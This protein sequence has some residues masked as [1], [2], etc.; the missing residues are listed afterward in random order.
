MIRVFFLKLLSLFQPK[1]KK[2]KRIEKEE[3]D[4]THI[5]SKPIINFP[6]RTGLN[7]LE[8]LFYELLHVGSITLSQNSISVNIENIY[9]EI[10]SITSRISFGCRK[11]KRSFCNFPRTKYNLTRP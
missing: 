5:I 3:E 4:G 2:R 1:K 6:F 7:L 10:I 9:F 8:E 11:A